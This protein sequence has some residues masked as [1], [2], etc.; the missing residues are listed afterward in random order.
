MSN[1]K[2]GRGRP[3]SPVTVSLGNLKVGEDVIVKSKSEAYAH[4]LVYRAR[5]RF[6]RAFVCTKVKS[7]V[8]KVI[9]ERKARAA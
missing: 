2:R 4:I 5:K 6:D 3:L 8:F 1:I 7:G 9:R